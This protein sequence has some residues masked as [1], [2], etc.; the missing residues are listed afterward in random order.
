MREFI[1]GLDWSVLTNILLRVLPALI[2][3]TLHELAHGYVAYRLGDDT[4]KNAGRLTLNPLKHIDPMGLIM[5]LVAGFGWAKAVPV[6]MYRFR[7]RKKGMAIT[8]IAGPITNILISIVSLF[9]FGL[10]ITPLYV[11]EIGYVILLLL[12]TTAYLSCAFAVFNLLPIPPLD[13]SKVAFSLM[14]DDK[15]R[16]LMRYEKYGMIILFALVVSDIISGPLS[17]LTGRLYDMLGIFFDIGLKIS[18]FI[19]DKVAVYGGM[20]VDLVSMLF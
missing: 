3:V 19:L 10:L 9:L 2:C 7:D 13:G 18:I 14:P 12:Q 16:W 15:Y 6:N 1:R 11:S 17:I 4:A 20:G 8:A 5:M